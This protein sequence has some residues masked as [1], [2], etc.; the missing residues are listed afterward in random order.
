LRREPTLDPDLRLKVLEAM[1][2]LAR[3]VRIRARLAS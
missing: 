1:D 2:S 3:A